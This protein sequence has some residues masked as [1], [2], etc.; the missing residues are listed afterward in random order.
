MDIGEILDQFLKE[1]DGK[2]YIAW[3]YKLFS[4][5][6]EGEEALNQLIFNP[7]YSK[8]KG[9]EKPPQETSC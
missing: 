5:S 3:D 4:L 9:Y 7:N 1:E 8:Q 2:K 6:K